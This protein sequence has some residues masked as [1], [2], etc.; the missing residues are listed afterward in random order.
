[1][2]EMT[3]LER[4]KKQNMTQAPFMVGCHKQT[5]RH[6]KRDPLESEGNRT[7][8]RKDI[9][10]YFSFVEPVVQRREK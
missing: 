4:V 3:I 8:A 7:E 5:N 9:L 10:L 1:M 2:E 6:T